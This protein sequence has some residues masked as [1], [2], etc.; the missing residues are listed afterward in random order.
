[1]DNFEQSIAADSDLT[2]ASVVKTLEYVLDNG[3]I[4]SLSDQQLEALGV[5]RSLVLDLISQGRLSEAQSL[6]QS[7]IGFIRIANLWAESTAE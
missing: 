4:A 2:L 1:M 6:L 3:S 7:S 5:A